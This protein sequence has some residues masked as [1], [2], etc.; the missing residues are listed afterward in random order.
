MKRDLAERL[1]KSIEGFNEPFVQLDALSHEIDDAEERM[2]FRRLIGEGMRAIA[3]DLVMP[4][5]RQFPDLDP[6]KGKL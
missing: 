6:D 4:I 1:L 2:R 5:V 3:F